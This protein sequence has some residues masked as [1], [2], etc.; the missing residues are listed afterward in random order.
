V[1]LHLSH[2]HPEIEPLQQKPE[3]LTI[4]GL[5]T[6]GAW[7]SFRMDFPSEKMNRYKDLTGRGQGEKWRDAYLN[8]KPDDAWN[9]PFLA[10]VDWW[11]GSKVKDVL[12]IAGGD[13]VLLSSLEEFYANFKVCRPIFISLYTSTSIRSFLLR[14]EGM[15]MPNPSLSTVITNDLYLVQTA[16]PNSTLVKGIDEGHV[17]P[18]Y[19]RVIGIKT[20]TQ[21]EKALREWLAAKLL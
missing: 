1:L 16:V 17:A 3:T 6:L 8:G 13:E 14:R 21:Q 2:P 5:F 4:G 15:E 9:Q 19:N 12:F 11:D 7:V 10:P 20:E 18:I